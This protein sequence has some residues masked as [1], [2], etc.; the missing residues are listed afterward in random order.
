MHLVM[1]GLL[2]LKGLRLGL[3]PRDGAEGGGPLGAGKCEVPASTTTVKP[4]RL[5]TKGIQ[6]GEVAPLR[7]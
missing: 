5:A 3:I 4:N 1:I 2:E 6:Y 7:P